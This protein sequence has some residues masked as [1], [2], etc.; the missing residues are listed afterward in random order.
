M[1]ISKLIIKGYRNFSDQIIEFN[2]GINMIIGPNNGGKTNILRALRLVFEPHC[3]FR[4]M[5]INDF[6]RP[7]KL[8]ILKSHSPKIVISA[9]IKPSVKQERELADDLRL[10]RMW[11]TKL[12]E[13][14]E[15]CLSYVFEL[16]S[17]L[18]DEY[19]SAMQS[20]SNETD[21]WSLIE[22]SFLRRYKYSIVGGSPDRREKADAESLNRFDVQ[23]LD[24]LRNVE[25]D[26][27]NSRSALLKEVL[28]FYI[29]YEIR[30]NPNIT[31]EERNL[32]HKAVR[33]EFKTNS[34]LVIKHLIDR[35][36][37]G[38]EHMLSYAS[39]TGASFNNA[40]P[41]FNG[42]ITEQDLY[43]ALRIVVKYKTGIDLPISHN[44][45]GYNNL[46]YISL[47]L[48]KIQADTDI[49][50]MG[51]NAVIFPI[52]IIEE[53][54]AHLHPSMQY[55]F[56]SFLKHD[57]S[58]K[59]RQIFVS[60]HSTQIAA[61]VS[62]EEII[63]V[64]RDHNEHVSIAYPY[65][66]FTNDEDGMKSYGYVKRFLDATRSDMLFADKIIFVE[67]IAEQLLLDVLANYIG[68]ILSDYHV[69]IVN[70]GG[71][72]FHHFLKMFDTKSSPYALNKRVLC[73]TDVD[74]TRK[75]KD[76]EKFSRCYPFELG[77]DHENYEYAINPFVGKNHE[78]SAV[79][80]IYIS[81]QDKEESKTF[82][83][84]LMLHNPKCKTLIIEG[85]TNNKKLLRIMECDNYEEAKKIFGTSKDWIK[86]VIDSLSA[87]GW[88]DEKKYKALIASLYLKSIDKGENALELSNLLT[89]N[90]LN[91]NID[92]DNFEDFIVPQYIVKG[93]QWLLK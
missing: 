47:L 80:N 56:L 55:K 68:Y 83:Y 35:L 3:R 79:S 21:A 46:I 6:H 5:S 50:R 73:L 9:I 31:K 13:N 51:E 42:D 11:L 89:E 92:S 72:Y 85:M 27:M 34:S 22:E 7:V 16:P 86:R 43:A 53:P 39:N 62:L 49:K 71:R 12:D 14:Y 91:K 61:A 76:K 44:G 4:R 78:F 10:I 8:D 45:L 88:N 74:P 67:G 36:K 1:Y 87:C 81:Y 48:A 19:I 32:Q 60:T 93:L 24:A 65:R 52:L 63:C 2:D 66:T 17:A 77:I 90:L 33:E 64:Q 38:K 37:T 69:C 15:A 82:E 57:Q 75:H 18:E 30:N 58:N 29:D 40:I 59:V 41:D 70:V 54:E 26:L 28:D 84:D 23:S 20:I 25:N